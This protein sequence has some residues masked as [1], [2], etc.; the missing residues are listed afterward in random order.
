MAEGE[1]SIILSKTFLKQHNLMAWFV[2][3]K[4]KVIIERLFS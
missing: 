3:F 1:V 2:K 4:T